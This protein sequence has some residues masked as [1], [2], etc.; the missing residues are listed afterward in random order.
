M[1]TEI[2]IGICALLG[3]LGGLLM[4]HFRSRTAVETAE[5]AAKELAAVT[6]RLVRVESWIEFVGGVG[7]GLSKVLERPTHIER[8]SLLRRF[9][10]EQEPPLT[11]KDYIRL[12]EILEF[13]MNE[14]D[15]D[16]TPGEKL[17]AAIN[18]ATIKYESQMTPIKVLKK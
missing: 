5:R 10:G 6:E 17:I 12:G 9:R 18:L 3:T 15:K 14:D 8:D 1:R 2:L 4:S 13:I 11:P 7:K 16:A